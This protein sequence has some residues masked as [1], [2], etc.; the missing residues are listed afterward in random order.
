MESKSTGALILITL[1]AA[2]PRH[3]KVL[4]TNETTKWPLQRN[5]LT[6]IIRLSAPMFACNQAPRF[7]NSTSQ[8]K[9]TSRLRSIESG[10]PSAHKPYIRTRCHDL[11]PRARVASFPQTL[12]EKGIPR[13]THPNPSNPEGLNRTLAFLSQLF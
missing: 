9:I 11:P 4:N 13:C 2:T 3:C 7:E 10:A 5:K 1:D 6:L 12:F 8:P